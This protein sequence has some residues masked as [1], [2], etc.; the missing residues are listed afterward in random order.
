MLLED[1]A[2][3][4]KVALNLVRKLGYKTHAV[5]NGQE[6]LDYLS[7]CCSSSASVP[8]LA[9]P[10]QTHTPAAILMD[11]QMPILDGYEATKRIRTD[12]RYSVV[13]N[14]PVIALTASAIQGDR[15]K[16]Q[17]SGMDDYLS[18]PVNKALLQG[19]LERWIPQARKD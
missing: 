12:H 6:A 11:C 14:V 17:A 7:S 5:W 13:K 3:N 1:N 16:C 4:Q 15:E 2:I 8:S 9:S 18:K 10:T 19:M